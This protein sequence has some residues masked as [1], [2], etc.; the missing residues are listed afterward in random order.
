MHLRSSW[1]TRL[2]AVSC[3][4]GFGW[5][6]SSC[7]SDTPSGFCAAPRSVAV[8]ISV[9]DSS[10]GL[11]AADGAIGTLVGAS[12]DDT[13]DHNDSLRISGGDQTGKYTVT[14]DKPGFLTWRVSDVQV[15]QQG[16]CG[17]VIPVDLSALLQRAT[18]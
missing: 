12:V 10:S 4:V 9:R 18:P 5:I 8:E 16:P 13:L 7:G 11:A 2:S 17:N 15:T 3:V 1:I 6:I 14:I